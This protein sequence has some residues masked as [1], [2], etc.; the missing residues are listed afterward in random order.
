MSCALVSLNRSLPAPPL[1]VLA[2][3]PAQKT[4]LA[5]SVTA[6]ASAVNACVVSARASTVIGGPAK[7]LLLLKNRLAAVPGFAVRAMVVKPANAPMVSKWAVNGDTAPLRSRLSVSLP[8]PLSLSAAVRVVAVALTVLGPPSR[9]TVSAPETRV[10]LPPA[11]GVPTATTPVSLVV[12]TAEE[13]VG[14]I[15]VPFV[16]DVWSQALNVSEADSGPAML[17]EKYTRVVALAA[18]S[19]AFVALTEGNACHVVPLLVE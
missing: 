16:P 6:E 14:S 11:V 1:S 17:G 3:P 12:E 15:A 2:P 8:A 5:P 18:S 7:T 4:K 9:N 13:N 10:T 19:S